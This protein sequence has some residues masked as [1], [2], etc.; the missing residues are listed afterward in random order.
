[1]SWTTALR[2]CGKGLRAPCVF[3]MAVALALLG[4][5]SSTSSI[6][7]HAAPV[8]LGFPGSAWSW[9][10]NAAGQ[11]GNGT[12]TTSNLPVAVSLPPGTTVTA[13]VGG[14]NHSLA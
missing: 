1:M 14:G 13:L 3:L 7:T 8:S 10:Y 5:I 6:A 9:G 4:T 2:N 12:N 11:L